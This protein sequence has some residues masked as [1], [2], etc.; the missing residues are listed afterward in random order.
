MR[1]AKEAGTHWHDRNARRTAQRPVRI[2]VLPQ[3]WTA[4]ARLA[5]ELDTT[6]GELVGTWLPMWL[7]AIPQVSGFDR[8]LDPSAAGDRCTISSRIC[9]PD[10][11]WLDVR[12]AART[13]GITTADLIGEA[14][15][16]LVVERGGTVRSPH[17][18]RRRPP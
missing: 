18:S 12:A 5:A 7:Q 15:I 8:Q 6:I 11:A 13:F 4:V 16:S 17:S 14:L 9:I 1:A 2:L 10:Y 3:V